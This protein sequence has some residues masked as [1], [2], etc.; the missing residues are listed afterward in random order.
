MATLKKILLWIAAI[1]VGGYTLLFIIALFGEEGYHSIPYIAVFGVV[2]FFI[3][4]A[5]CRSRM[6]ANSNPSATPSD[7]VATPMQHAGPDRVS[8]K[9]LPVADDVTMEN[10][11]GY[12]D[13]VAVDF[14][15]ATAHMDSACAI[16]I[17]AVKNLKPVENFYSLIKPPQNKYSDFNIGIHGITPEMTADAPTLTELWPQ[18]EKYFNA[19]VPVVA[20]NAQFDMSAL[21]MSAG[22]ELPDLIYVD[23]MTLASHFVDG[24][25][26]LLDCASELGIKVSGYEHHDARDDAKLCAYVTVACL[27]GLKCDTLWEYIAR[28]SYGPHKYLSQL[29]PTKVMGGARTY[30]PKSPQE[31]QEFDENS[32]NKD[33]PLSG[34]GITFTGELSIDRTTA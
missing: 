15:T 5:L 3:I 7:P 25:P 23:A 2:L 32:I 33:G 22:V 1:V 9:A 34:K 24:K 16:G 29:K 6:T 11:V 30:R 14:E 27:C 28:T 4:R 31:P 20:Y 18:L 17:F 13:F 12:F 21:Q 26:G 19:H 10:E 8:N